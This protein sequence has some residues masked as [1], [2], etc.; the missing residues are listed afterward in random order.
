MLVI[1]EPFFCSS[2]IMLLVKYARATYKKVR[3]AQTRYRRFNLLT[4]QPP[5]IGSLM[6]HTSALLDA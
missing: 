3:Q 6:C 4:E 1:G 5:V 2:Y